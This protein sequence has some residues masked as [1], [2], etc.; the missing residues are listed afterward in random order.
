MEENQ[1]GGVRKINDEKQTGSL[2][3]TISTVIGMIES[4]IIGPL[5]FS[6]GKGWALITGPHGR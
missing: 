2:P 4:A 5:S 1:D 6:R 3:A